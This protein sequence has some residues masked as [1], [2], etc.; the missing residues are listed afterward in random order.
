[1]LKQMLRSGGFEIASNWF[2]KDLGVDSTMALR[3]AGSTRRNRMQKANRRAQKV[4]GIVR[5]NKTGRKLVRTGVLPVASYGVTVAGLSSKQRKALRNTCLTAAGVAT[6][7][8]CTTTA[9]RMLWSES[10][11]PVV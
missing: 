11:D 3:R 7:S 8:W 4:R 5:D 9:V 2:G 1:M 6:R 10:A